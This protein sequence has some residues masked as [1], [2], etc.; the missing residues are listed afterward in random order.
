M[1]KKVYI[2][3][4]DGQ[5]QYAQMFLADGWNIAD[6]IADASLVHFTGG[7]DVTPELYGCG[8]HPRTMNSR[9]RDD[10]EQAVFQEARRMGLPMSGICRGGQFLNVMNGGRMYQH[11]DGHAI[12]GTHKATDV[13]SGMIFEV[14]STHH[15][16]MIAGNNGS[17]VLQVPKSLCTHKDYVDDQN[18]IYVVEPDANN[19]D[20]EAV[21]YTHSKCFCFQPHPEYASGEPCREYFFASVEARL[22]NEWKRMTKLTGYAPYYDEDED[23]EYE[24]EV[25]D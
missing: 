23:E 16:M 22:F 14:T 25:D 6:D 17:V 10:A 7:E 9:R 12:G 19:Q 20:V 11:V 15:Q 2:V 24:D 1:K 13:A 18:E 5:C 21:V 4:S 8:Q 3:G